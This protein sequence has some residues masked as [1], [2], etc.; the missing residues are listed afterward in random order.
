MK[1]VRRNMR[2][3]ERIY[4]NGTQ[5]PTESDECLHETDER[6]NG[7]ENDENEVSNISPVD[8]PPLGSVRSFRPSSFCIWN[9]WTC[10]ERPL[11]FI[12]TENSFFCKIRDNFHSTF[13]G[14]I[15]FGFENG[16]CASARTIGEGKILFVALKR[17]STVNS[18]SALAI[19]ENC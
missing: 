2:E 16:Y 9:V 11:F 4:E 17:R 3:P 1:C 15:W 8:S 6:R 13:S 14:N 18:V 19:K 12:L 5:T 7:N 10:D